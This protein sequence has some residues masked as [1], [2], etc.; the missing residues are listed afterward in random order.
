MK[1]V[2][3]MAAA[4]TAVT[5]ADASAAGRVRARNGCGCSQPATPVYAA[6]RPAAPCG[7]CVTPHATP[8]MMMPSAPAV[9]LGPTVPA[10]PVAP[11]GHQH[12]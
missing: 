3:V 4:V 11:G 6:P 8:G 10:A 1:R 7:S 9:V 2:L 12:H 5:A